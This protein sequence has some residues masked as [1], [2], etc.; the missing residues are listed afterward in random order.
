MKKNKLWIPGFLSVILMFSIIFVTGCKT[1]SDEELK[2]QE[3]NKTQEQQENQKKQETPVEI[4]KSLTAIEFSKKMECGW[5]LGNTLDARKGTDTTFP[6]NEGLDSETYWSEELTTEAIIKTGINAGGYKTIRI[7]VT[8]CNH[9]TDTN[10]TIDPKWMARVKQIVDWAIDAGYY[11]I[12]N[13]HHSVH[14]KMNNPLKKCEGYIIRST[15]EQ[16]SKAFL[17]AIWK[18]ITTT[19]NNSYD[20][21]LIFETMNEPRN[22]SHEHMWSLD[23]ENCEECKQ[24]VR[25]L[26]ELNQMILDIIRASGGN[27]A[28]RFVMIPAIG[29]D[30]GNA[31]NDAFKMPVDTAENKLMVTVH[32]YPLDS[33]GTGKNSHHFDFDTKNAIRVAMK[34]LNEKYVSKGIPV[35][36]GECG[37]ARKAGTDWDTGKAITDYVVTYEDR[38]QCFSYFASLAGKYSIVFINWDCGG[39]YGMATIDRK[40]CKVY[41]PDYNAAIV[42]AWKDANAN[43]DSVS[44]AA[45][46]EDANLSDFKVWDNETS[47]YNASTGKVSFGANWKGGDIWIGDKDVSDY[48]KVVLK[49]KDATSD[50]IVKVV[51]SDNTEQVESL[52]EATAKKTETSVSIMIN[53]SKKV[54]QIQLIGKA[55]AMS[56][57]LEKLTF[58]VK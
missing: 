46:D 53:N 56:V 23:L 20:E 22:T 15:D 40:N 52:T 51:Y 7:P 37:A 3:Q 33:G 45:Q 55:E 28:N 32:D 16:E 58:V 11:V 44:V 12:L 34:N 30:I 13:E 35:V 9:L 6:S 50:F 2:N 47:S 8:W 4:N 41:E 18:Q 48:S 36:L 5:N 49:Y 38:L 43:P 10:Y 27:N 39:Q 29:T 14:D 21:H 25:I 17:Q 42:K 24:D 26:N 19:F 1:D 54:R 57:I 31:L